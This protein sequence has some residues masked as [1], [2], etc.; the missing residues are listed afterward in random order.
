M[1]QL[2]ISEIACQVGLRT[3]AIRYYEQIGIL[4]PAQRIGGRRRYDRTV[5]YRLAIVQQARLAGFSLHEIRA[6]FFGFQ[7]GTRAD[8]RWRR[9]AE[10]KLVEL[11]T[12]AEQVLTMQNLLRRMQS[13]CHC[14]SLELCGKAIFTKGLS[15][16]E[17]SPLPVLSKAGSGQTLLDPAR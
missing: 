6:L 4:P 15:K 7:E 14:K 16:I 5:L 1:S 2:S 12:I 10:R 8:V 9:L 13:G 17:R 3:S 11:N